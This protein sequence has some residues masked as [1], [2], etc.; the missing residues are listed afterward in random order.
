[1][2]RLRHLSRACLA[3]TMDA[4]PRII[5]LDRLCLYGAGAARLHEEL[6]PVTARWTELRIRK[7]PLSPYARE[8]ET[9]TLALLEE[10][11]AEKSPRPIP[12]EIIN[13][14][15]TAAPR[16]VQ[17]LLGHLQTLGQEY[18]KDAEKKLQIR[19][20]AEAKAMRQILETQKVHIAQTAA[21]YQKETPGFLF[22]ALEDERRQ[23]QDNKRYWAKRLGLLEQELLTEPERIREIYQVKARRIEP[24]GLVYLWP[25]T[26]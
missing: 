18:A 1:M 14:L 3:H 13:K 20:D 26:G 25:V 23:L 17:E 19:A 9:K 11:L 15:Q 8:A 21:K 7:T 5:L 2:D 4:I 10:A 22:P 16:D 6:I 24:V 12:S